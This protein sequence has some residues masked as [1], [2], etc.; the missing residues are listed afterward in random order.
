MSDIFKII[1]LDHTN[2]KNMIVF[3]GEKGGTNVN[4]LFT[5]DK[6]NDLFEGLFSRVVA[7][8]C[9]DR[10]GAVGLID[11]LI[12]EGLVWNRFPI[13]IKEQGLRR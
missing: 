4:K 2:N 9:I 11:N 13:T 5:E 12:G 3:F 10:E 8:F 6:G 1:Y 7:T